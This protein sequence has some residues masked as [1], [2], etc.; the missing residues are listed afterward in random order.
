[1]INYQRGFIKVPY[2]G[3]A[4]NKAQ[5]ITIYA[6]KKEWMAKK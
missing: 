1:M 5:L 6:L 3:T 2:E 4:K